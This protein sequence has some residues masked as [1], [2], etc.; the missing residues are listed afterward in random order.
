MLTVSVNSSATLSMKVKVNDDVE[1][2]VGFASIKE[3]NVT[4]G[5]TTS[6]DVF[7][8]VGSKLRELANEIAIVR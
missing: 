1:L 3:L 2:V 7:T 8:G 5:S 6:G 4:A